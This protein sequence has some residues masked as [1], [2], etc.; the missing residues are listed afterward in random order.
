MNTTPETPTAPVSDAQW[1]A[2]RNLFHS[3]AIAVLILTGTFFVFLFRQ[4][5]TV[6]NNTEEMVKFLHQYEESDVPEMIERIRIKLDDYRK[7]DPGYTPIYVK[8]FGTNPPARPMGAAAGK[9]AP[10][11]TNAAGTNTAR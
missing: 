7:K 1:R 6:K 10:V 4:V 5:M 3:L 9:V 8:Y 11:S 2:M